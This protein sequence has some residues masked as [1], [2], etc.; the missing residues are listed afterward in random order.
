MC[1]L[2][3]A[4][5]FPDDWLNFRSACVSFPSKIGEMKIGEMICSINELYFRLS[6]FG[7]LTILTIWKFYSSPLKT[8]SSTPHQEKLIKDDEKNLTD[9]ED[10]KKLTDDEDDEK[11]QKY[12]RRGE[13][14]TEEEENKLLEE[15]SKKKPIK[16]IAVEHGRFKFAIEMRQTYIAK[17]LNKNGT[18]PSDIALKLNLSEEQIYNRTS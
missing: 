1:I 8:F 16:D 13:K 10:E 7:W 11:K 3:F 5:F 4:I 9:E 18:S 14:W 12:E 15:F 17:K 2:L 6:V